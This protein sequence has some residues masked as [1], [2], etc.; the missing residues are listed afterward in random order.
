[1]NQTL[2]VIEKGSDIKKIK[3]EKHETQQV[4]QDTLRTR[5][6]TFEFS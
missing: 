5:Q 4:P 3:Q 1:M 2:P 6:V